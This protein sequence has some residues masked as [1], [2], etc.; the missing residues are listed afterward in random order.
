MKRIA[1]LFAIGLAAQLAGCGSGG[2][3]GSGDPNAVVLTMGPFTVP[4]GKEV[5]KCQEFV[6][7]FGG[8]DQDVSEYEVHMTEGSHHF[9]LFFDDHNADVPLADCALGGFEYHPYPFGA[10]SPDA[11]MTYPAGVGSLVPGSTGFML[12]AHY[13]NAS[14]ETITGTVTAVLHKA[15]PGSIQQHAGVIFMNDLTIAIPP[16]VHSATSTCTIPTNVNILGAQSHMHQR[17]ID[18][19]STAGGQPLYMTDKWSDPTPMVFDPPMVMAGGTRVSWTCDYNN[20]TSS[21]LTFGEYAQSSVM[22]ILLMQYYPVA[23]SANPT[24]SCMAQGV[25]H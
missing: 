5:F 22:C 14:T 18:F 8:M 1:T 17:A 9:F 3:P 20:D 7:P 13:I 21:T 15:P 19:T 16:G 10:Q 25:N 2:G 11:T 23:N 6:N 12:N 4:P 24:L